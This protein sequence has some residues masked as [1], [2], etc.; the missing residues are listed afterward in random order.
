[1]CLDG[2]LH[3]K[4]SVVGRAS[5]KENQGDARTAESRGSPRT[6]EET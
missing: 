5:V 6:N 1:M 2:A 3:R 4:E